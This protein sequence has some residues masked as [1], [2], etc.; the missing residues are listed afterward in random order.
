MSECDPV[1]P[2]TQTPQKELL[3]THTSCC[4]RTEA[5]CLEEGTNKLLFV[6]V[7]GGGTRHALPDA[8]GVESEE[9]ESSH[10]PARRNPIPARASDLLC[11]VYVCAYGFVCVFE[12]L[13]VCVR[14]CVCA[15]FS[16]PANLIGW[17]MCEP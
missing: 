1:R 10:T 7:S 16:G 13:F 17:Q 2:Q 3:S 11:C 8:Q 4:L 9:E 15:L 14:V 5:L 12:C 6:V